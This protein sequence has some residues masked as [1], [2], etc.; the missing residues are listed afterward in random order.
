VKLLDRFFGGKLAP[1]WEV[2]PG[3]TLWKLEVTPAGRLV[4]EARDIEAKRMSLFA[5]DLSTGSL[6]FSDRA[7][8]EPWWVALEAV[9]GEIAIVHRY[10]KPDMP[11]VLGAAAIDAASGELLWSDDSL[12]IVCGTEEILLAQRGAS[13]DAPRLLFIDARSGSVL[14]EAAEERASIFMQACDDNERWRGWTSAEELDDAHPLHAELD[15]LLDRLLDDRRGTAEVARQGDY[16]IV[17]AYVRS[18]RSADA[19]LQGQLD[20]VLLVL[21]GGRVVFRETIA[22]GLP[23]PTG[24]SFFLRHGILH[25]IRQGRTLV[26]LDLRSTS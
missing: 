6:L 20:N 5:I 2:T 13:T 21:Q 18:R 25:F 26:A 7:L 11:N 19:M 22:T 3:A 1:L 9:A 16:V 14:E 8:D 23:A 10:P 17:S 4:G 15:P 12:R 24:D